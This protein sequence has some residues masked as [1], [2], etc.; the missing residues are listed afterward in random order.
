MTRDEHRTQCIDRGAKA[1]C[2]ANGDNWTE[3]DDEWRNQIYR[4]LFTAA[5]DS[6]HGLALVLNRGTYWGSG[7][8]HAEIVAGDL[9]NPPE[10]KP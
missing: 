9:T 6:I 8:T 7:M 10:G 1:L 2:I 4:E 5:F 3:I